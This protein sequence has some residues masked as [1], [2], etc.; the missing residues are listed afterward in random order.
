MRLKGKV[1]LI[2]GAGSGIGRATAL[3]FAREGAL[4]VAADKDEQQAEKTQNLIHQAGGKCEAKFIDVSQ[5]AQ[6]A[7]AIATVVNTW[8]QLDVLFNNAGI[9][10]L[11]PVTDTTEAEWAAI[12]IMN[13]DYSSRGKRGKVKES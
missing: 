13:L 1:S 7:D 12:L 4:V 5:E 10:L 11:K 3:L 8:G 9:S 2:T 6:V